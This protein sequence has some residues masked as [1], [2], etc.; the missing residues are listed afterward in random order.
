[1]TAQ[2]AAQAQTWIYEAAE[3]NANW[4]RQAFYDGAANDTVTRNSIVD[5]VQQLGAR[6]KALL[7]AE[8]KRLC[9]QIYNSEQQLLGPA[10]ESADALMGG[11]AGWAGAEGADGVT[12]KG[13][14]PFDTL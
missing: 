9:V 1:M 13:R 14:R 6:L 8:V 11:V 3:G 7:A 12:G 5:A 10:R 2:K 4:V